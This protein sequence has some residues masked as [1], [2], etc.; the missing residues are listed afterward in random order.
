MTYNNSMKTAAKGMAPPNGTRSFIF[1]NQG[2]GGMSLDN[3]FTLPGF[4][5]VAFLNP[6]KAPSHTLGTDKAE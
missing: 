6:M 5:I 2:Y 3:L 1:K 4:L